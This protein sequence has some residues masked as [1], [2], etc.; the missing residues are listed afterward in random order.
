MMPEKVLCLY[1]IPSAK[2]KAKGFTGRNQWIKIYWI[3]SPDSCLAEWSTPLNE[4][5]SN[6]TRDNKWERNILKTLLP[7]NTAMVWMLL[8]F[9]LLRFPVHTVLIGISN[10]IISKHP[11]EG[12][13][14]LPTT[15]ITDLVWL[16]RWKCSTLLPV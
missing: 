7:C 5:L 16:H 1:Y 14:P 8:F 6:R 10:C 9:F 13:L 12:I 15:S 2:I 11:A 3:Y 4:G